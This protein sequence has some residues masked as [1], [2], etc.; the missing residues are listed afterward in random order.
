ML[1]IPCSVLLHPLLPS[2]LTVLDH[3]C[4]APCPLVS[5]HLVCSLKESWKR[6]K[7]AHLVPGHSKLGWQ[8]SVALFL[9][10]MVRQLCPKLQALLTT[11]LW[12]LLD[13]SRCGGC[14]QVWQWLPALHGLW[15]LAAPF[16]LSP[17]LLSLSSLGLGS[18]RPECGWRASKCNSKWTQQAALP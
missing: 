10:L 14:F 4:W 3:F 13:A 1:A 5:G 9:S 12:P 17:Q 6:R 16:L 7:W 15:V 2:R 18:C 11:G 8:S